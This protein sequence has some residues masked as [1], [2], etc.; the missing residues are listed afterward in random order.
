[1]NTRARL[2]FPP[3]ELAGCLFAAI[4]RDTRGARLSDAERRNF[5]PAS[6]LVALTQV[7]VGELRLIGMDGSL[8]DA[9]QSP[10]L[11]NSFLT[12]PQDTPTVSWSADDLLAL[13]LGFYP[14]GLARLS[15]VCDPAA[16]L[17]EAARDGTDAEATWA[18]FCTAL[19]PKWQ[20]SRPHGWVGSG[21]LADWARALVA[22]AAISGPG[23]TLRSLERRLRRWGGPTRRTLAF[24]TAIEDLHRIVVHST[25]APLAQIAHEAGYADQSHMGRALRRVTG[26]SPALLNQLIASDEAFWCY[27][28]LGERF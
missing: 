12:P 20:Q 17:V 21:R 23:Q 18:R 10:A 4:V 27:R 5:F 2:L 16:L 7:I 1:M 19:M 22:R 15:A 3:P 8:K 6:P 9:P 24:Y 25:G 14:E 28:L 11:P 13:T 26:F